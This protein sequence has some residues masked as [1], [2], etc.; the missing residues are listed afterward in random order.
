VLQHP[1]MIRTYPEPFTI[2]YLCG[3]QM[4]KSYNSSKQMKDEGL[5]V[6]LDQIL[7][8]ADDNVVLVK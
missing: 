1:A 8:L 5:F 3:K 7:S 2:E 6:R 4:M